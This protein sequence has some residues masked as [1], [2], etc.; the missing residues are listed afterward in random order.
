MISRYFRDSL[1]NYKAL[2]SY[3]G[4]LS[5]SLFKIVNSLFQ[6]SFFIMVSKY[7]FGQRDGT[8]WV[9]GNAFMLSS[10]N[11]LFGVGANATYE[12]VFGT[13]K[14][15]VASTTS[16]LSRYIIQMIMHVLDGTLN[17]LLGILYG[18]LIWG[19][20]ISILQFLQ[21]IG[22][23]VI[24]MVSISGFSLLVGNLGLVVR[25]MTLVLNFIHMQILICA[26]A[27]YS[28]DSMPMIVKVVS[29]A[30]P[31]SHSII[32]ARAVIMK[33]DD[34]IIKNIFYELIIGIAYVLLA[35]G[36]H[37]LIERAAIKKASLELI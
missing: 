36:V 4:I 32:A 25:D 13:L 15:Y 22:I 1:Y 14:Y 7:L 20:R 8:F 12:R 5:Y 33:S 29:K 37:F 28:I 3:Y 23:S 26:G 11:S 9:I 27:N 31:L 34:G 10:C 30:T 19:M 2:F 16:I 6:I 17:I 21:M 24:A 35:A 18:M